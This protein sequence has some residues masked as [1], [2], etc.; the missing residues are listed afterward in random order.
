MTVKEFIQE[1]EKNNYYT[2]FEIENINGDFS[3]ISSHIKPM[4]ATDYYITATDIYK[5]E[6][7]Y[8]GVHGIVQAFGGMSPTDFEIECTAQEY[9]K[10]HT[11]TYVPKGSRNTYYDS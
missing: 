1:I 5:L 3:K 11:V 4:Y 6:D 2:L 8:V 9:E 10:V 7:G